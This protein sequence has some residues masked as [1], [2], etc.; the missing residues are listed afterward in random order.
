MRAGPIH[1]N[2][3]R[4]FETSRL[5]HNAILSR[6]FDCDYLGF[7]AAWNRSARSAFPQGL[8]QKGMTIGPTFLVCRQ[9]R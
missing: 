9:R 3:D 8:L 4:I 1:N 2:F 5:P 6:L 7:G